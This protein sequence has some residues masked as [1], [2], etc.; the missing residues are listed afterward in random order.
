MKHLFRSLL[1]CL[2]LCADELTITNHS[3]YQAIAGKLPIFEYEDEE[4][5]STFF[6]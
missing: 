2:G 5:S 6:D 1:L 3:H 4:R